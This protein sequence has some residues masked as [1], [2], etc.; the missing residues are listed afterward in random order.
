MVSRNWRKPSFSPI[1]ILRNYSGRSMLRDKRV[2]GW[3]ALAWISS[4]LLGVSVAAVAAHG[5][6]L[7]QVCPR[8]AAGATVSNPPELRSHNGILEVALHLK[9]QQTF[10]GEGPVRYCME[11]EV[12]CGSI[13]VTS[14]AI[15]LGLTVPP[16]C[17][18][19]EVIRTAIHAGQEFECRVKIPPD[20][21]PGLYWYHPHPHGFSERQEQGGASGALIVEGIED[22]D[23]SL[24][25]LRQRVLVLRD[26]SPAYVGLGEPSAPAWDISLNYVPVVY[27]QYQP[28]I[29]Q[30][31]SAKRELWRVLNAAAD[32][33]FDLQVLINDVPQ[34]V[35]FRGALPPR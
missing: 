29:V 25:R 17:H 23:P 19:D 11:M 15:A 22:L 24:S 31:R 12:G 18:Q 35:C 26:Q 34:A 2:A 32:T 16:T 14:A 10:V 13:H 5:Q 3:E 4:V 27:P 7:D 8:P 30:T 21:P 6:S 1:R 28:A 20:E 9:F 33:I